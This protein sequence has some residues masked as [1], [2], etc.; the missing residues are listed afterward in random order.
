MFEYLHNRLLEGREVSNQALGPILT[1]GAYSANDA[2]GGKLI[3]SGAGNQ[4]SGSGFIHGL[5]IIDISQV[6][7]AL[8][9]R[10]FDRNFTAVA[11]NAAFALSDADAKHCIAIIASSTYVDNAATS[12]IYTVAFSN[13]I[14][15]RCYG[16]NSLYGQLECTATPTYST[17]AD[18]TVILH[19]GVIN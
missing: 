9:L 1:A 17:T 19:V 10:L 5:T 12:S 14:A 13:P 11:D 16:G 3:F 7:A 2:V 18:L 6:K 8:R 4:K 15:Y